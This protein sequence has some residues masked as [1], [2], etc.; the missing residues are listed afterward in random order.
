MIIDNEWYKNRILW[1]AKKNY[2]FNY[3]CIKY[4]DLKSSHKNCIQKLIDKTEVPVIVF[5]ENCNKWT[6]LCT[7]KLYSYYDDVLQCVDKDNF[8]QKITPHIDI[9]S[10]PISHNLAK[11]DAK[12]LKMNETGEY[13]WLP[14]SDDLWNFWG[15]LQMLAKLR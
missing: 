9:N 7:N 12:W 4:D 8:N 5:F 1:K 2:L 15:L 14:S 10:E 11:K 13:I 6:L 3:N